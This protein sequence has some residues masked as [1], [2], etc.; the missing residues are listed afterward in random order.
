MRGDGV[1]LVESG[2]VCGC[3]GVGAGADI[4]NG[5]TV[6]PAAYGQAALRRRAGCRALAE[7]PAP[8]RSMV[9][10]V[11]ANILEGL[12]GAIELGGITVQFE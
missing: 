3:L 8:A 10:A 9:V 2:R 5:D 1:G 12:C 7:R 6:S 11:E 4:E